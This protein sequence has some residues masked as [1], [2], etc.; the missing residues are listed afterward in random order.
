MELAE[1][2]CKME[3]EEFGVLR[4]EE[5]QKREMDSPI[6]SRK[7]HDTHEQVYKHVSKYLPGKEK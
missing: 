5:N 6:R 3:G 2:L 1:L 4:E 7:A